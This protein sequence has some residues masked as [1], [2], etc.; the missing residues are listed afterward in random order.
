MTSAV[1]S[2]A[3]PELP[4]IGDFLPGYEATFM[5]G[6]GGPKNVPAEIVDRLNREIN[7][8][9]AEP[10]IKVRLADLGTVPLPMTSTDFSKLLAEETQKWARVIHTANLKPE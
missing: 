2:E 8:A 4:T 7:A 5:V 10:G 1:R 3:L 9:L 6:L